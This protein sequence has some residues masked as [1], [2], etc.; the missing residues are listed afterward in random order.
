[1]H[2]ELRVPRKAG[3][4]AAVVAPYFHGVRLTFRL[5][6]FAAAKASPMRLCASQSAQDW[7]MPRCISS[8]QMPHDMLAILYLHAILFYT[9]L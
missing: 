6:A 4:G 1:M 9:T 3:M 8:P 7:H 5:R 2:F